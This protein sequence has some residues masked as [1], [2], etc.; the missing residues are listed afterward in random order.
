MLETVYIF[1][2]G[3]ILIFLM[4][5]AFY[6]LSLVDKTKILNSEFII[7]N[8]RREGTD[9]EG[10]KWWFEFAFD[11]EKVF[12]E[13]EPQFEASGDY[14]IVKEEEHL[15]TLYLQ[16][17][18]GDLEQGKASLSVAID[19]KNNQLTIDQRAGYKRI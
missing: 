14:K 12:L 2:G 13:G 15:L 6:Y 1:L 19:K 7:G 5:V 18:T 9:S 10:Q 3:L 16:N 4:V 11:G 8:W 17:M